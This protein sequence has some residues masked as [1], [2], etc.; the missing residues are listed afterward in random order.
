[1]MPQ[2]TASPCVKRRYAV[3]ASR[4]CPSVCPRFR[5][6]RS[7]SSLSSRATTSALSRQAP[8]MASS[9]D[10]ALHPSRPGGAERTAS[11]SARSPMSPH[12]RT[13]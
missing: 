12:F 9:M 8:A 4:A 1:M 13:S 11:N 6:R 5:T 2:P 10:D 3:A 7:P